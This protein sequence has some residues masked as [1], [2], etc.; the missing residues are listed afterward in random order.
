M[1]FPVE[2]NSSIKLVYV[3][4]FSPREVFIYI[5]HRSS[6]RTTNNTS[7]IAGICF[8]INTHIYTLTTFVY[9]KIYVSLV[10]EFQ[11]TKWVI[12]IRKSKTNRQ[13]NGQT[14]STKGQTT[15]YKTYT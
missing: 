12:R 6:N 2:H 11:D 3:L 10:K 7:Y 5:V 9:Y 14:K 15:T 1:A 4:F 13:R 8:F